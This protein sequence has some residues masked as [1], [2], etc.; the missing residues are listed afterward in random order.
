MCLPRVLCSRAGGA[1]L[2]LQGPHLPALAGK[3]EI[4]YWKVAIKREW[5]VGWPLCGEP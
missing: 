5:P 4:T 2:E 3:D 1:G